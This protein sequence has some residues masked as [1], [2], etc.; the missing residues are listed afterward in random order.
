MAFCLRDSWN[1]LQWGMTESP[2]PKALYGI[3]SIKV[4][5]QFKNALPLALH[6][7]CQRNRGEAKICLP[8]QKNPR[9]DSVREGSAAP[10]LSLVSVA[11]N[12]HFLAWKNPKT[13]SW[14]DPMLGLLGCGFF[15]RAL[16]GPT[17]IPS[18]QKAGC[19]ILVTPP[20]PP[21]Y[22]GNCL[23]QSHKNAVNLALRCRQWRNF[24]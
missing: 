18:Q 17:P 2:M 22:H 9:Q 4:K 12:A 5:K 11:G 10:S 14:R 15:S 1:R 19:K 16:V 21:F 8:P 23:G 6:T 24:C 7:H 20:P 3:G 13:F